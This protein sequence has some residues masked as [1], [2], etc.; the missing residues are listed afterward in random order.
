MA[1]SRNI[2]PAFFKNEILG[3]ADPLYS[4]LFE[5]LLVLADRAGKLE[6]RPMRI[7][8]EIFP[9]REGLDLDCMLNW[10][11]THGFITRYTADGV[12]CIRVDEFIKHQNPHKN[13]SA[14]ELPD[15]VKECTKP[16]IIGTPS[17]NIGSA[18]A[19]SLNLIPDSLNLI[20][21]TPPLAPPP[22]VDNPPCSAAHAVCVVLAR[23]NI[24][25]P[26]PQDPALVALLQAGADVAAFTQAAQT[27]VTQ[28]NARFGYVMGIVRN[29][30]QQAAALTAVAMAVPGAPAFAAVGHRVDVSRMTVPSRPGQ[31]PTLA[32]LDREKGLVKP[33]PPDFRA[34][35]GWGS[36]KAAQGHA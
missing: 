29:R 8:A 6:D 31:D 2:K 14:S 35:M 24:Q 5:G 4:L 1:R 23:E 34:R 10:L 19:D 13:E 20:P 33:M 27:A 21:D 26:N 30:L 36:P 7:K 11:Q 22:P 18:R 15:P 9:Y 32:K 3:V 25:S 28:G 16:E 12:K 17:E